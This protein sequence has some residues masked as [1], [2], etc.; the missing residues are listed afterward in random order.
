MQLNPKPR[1][2]LDPLSL[3][4][5]NTDLSDQPFGLAA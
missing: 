4:F 5:L 3:L 1:E 2:S